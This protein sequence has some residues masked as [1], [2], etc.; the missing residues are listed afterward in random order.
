VALFRVTE[1]GALSIHHAW[2]RSAIGSTLTSLFVGLLV[3][4]L[5]L[6]VGC[7]DPSANSGG[8]VT[9][10]AAASV[11]AAPPAEEPQEE[12]GDGG[13]APFV[14]DEEKLSSQELEEL[15][16]R[17]ALYPDELVA[18]V[19]PAATFPLDVVEAARFLEENEG[20]SEPP[21]DA[22]WDPSVIALLAFPSVLA[23]M[24]DD[25]AWTR[26]LGDA[27]WVQEADVYDAI[28][29]FRRRVEAAGN[30][31]SN[32]KVVVVKEKET[33]TIVPAE[34]E[35]VYVPVYQPQT[36]VV[37]RTSVA[38]LIIWGSAIAFTAWAYSLSWGRHHHHHVHYHRHYH[39]RY[40]H[41]HYKKHRK[42]YRQSSK[43]GHRGSS[44]KPS[45]RPGPGRPGYG[46][47]KPGKPGKPGHAGSHRPGSSW[48]KPGKP[49]GGQAGRPGVGKPGK[50]GGGK[51]AR[52]GAGKTARPRAGQGSYGSYDR[53][54]DTR[55]SSARGSQ[56]RQK[57]TS[58]TSR[59]G[60]SASAGGSRGGSYGSYGSGRSVNRSSSRGASSR[61]G[62]SRGGGGRS[63]GGGG[64][65]R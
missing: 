13:E 55:R 34:P 41:H 2:P 15:V 54:N 16:G 5:M 49:G 8:V 24:S 12:G 37:H 28:Q 59:R 4:L 32:E 25:I 35:V 29:A 39:R 14:A 56:S 42:H 51:A 10:A 48:G 18:Q 30:L 57:Q 1:E 61:G 21:E 45:H 7:G 47:R 65:R 43:Y 17:I 9:A 19:L 63:R 11:D 26:Q 62:S 23:M 22:A 53:G 6:P 44:W 27:L 58:H 46:G 38:P 20:A 60:S 31:E 3:F 52:P 40:S 36:V 33:I 50:P 64:R